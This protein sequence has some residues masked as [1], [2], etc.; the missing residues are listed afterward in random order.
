MVSEKCEQQMTEKR[1][2]RMRSVTS[3]AASSGVRQKVINW[4]AMMA[5]FFYWNNPCKEIYTHNQQ[6]ITN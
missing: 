1:G 5:S 2:W 3:M 6:F 4:G